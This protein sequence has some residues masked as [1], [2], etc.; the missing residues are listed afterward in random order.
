MKKNLFVISALVLALSI[1]LVGCQKPDEEMKRAQQAISDAKAAGA[2]EY[3]PGDISSAEQRLAEGKELMEHFRYHEAKEKFEEAYRL[4]MIAKGKKPAVARTEPGPGQPVAPASGKPT[5]HT[6]AKGDCLWSIAEQDQ[7]YDDPF[8]W[9]L[10]YSENRENI[11][12]T[13]HS[14]G[15]NNH[16]E[17]WIFP[18]QK[19]DIPRDSTTEEIKAARHRAGAPTPAQQ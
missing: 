11:D 2:S 4:A 5:S 12:K 1:I 15:F 14:H 8:S 18:D 3:A 16:E 7:M 6:V 10:I 13:A 17:N 19:L 9:P